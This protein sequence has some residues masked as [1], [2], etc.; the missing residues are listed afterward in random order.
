MNR[1]KFF[2]LLPAVICGFIFLISPDSLLAKGRFEKCALL[3]RPIVNMPRTP[4]GSV[5]HNAK[6]LV[7]G[8]CDSMNYYCYYDEE[9]KSRLAKELPKEGTNIK[10]FWATQISLYNSCV[11]YI[12]AMN[13]TETAKQAKDAI[14]LKQKQANEAKKI[15]D[16][17][18]KFNAVKIAANALSN[19]GKY[20]KK[21]N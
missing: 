8:L 9:H 15:N 12:E 6:T 16:V 7:I 17:Y 11:K 18:E 4:G 5:D 13:E 20:S 3:G 19:K 1:S 21:K 2:L 14:M 10:A